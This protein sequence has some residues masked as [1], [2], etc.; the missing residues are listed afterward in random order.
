VGFTSAC[1]RRAPAGAL[2]PRAPDGLDLDEQ[3]LLRH[4]IAVAP[5]WIAYLPRVSVLGGVDVGAAGRCRPA[6]ADDSAGANAAR[7]AVDLAAEILRRRAR[8]AVAA[9]DQA[10]L[11]QRAVETIA[12]TVHD[13]DESNPPPTAR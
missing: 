9:R 6:G 3:A 4:P 10:Q 13:G 5:A 11:D 7:A 1:R 2:A 12:E 8:A